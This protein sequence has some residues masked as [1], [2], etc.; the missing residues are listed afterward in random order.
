MRLKAALL[1][2][3]VLTGAAPLPAAAESCRRAVVFTLPGITWADVDEHRPP[4][5]LEAATKGAAGSV[6]VRT[7]SSRTSYASGFATLGAGARVEAGDTALGAPSPPDEAGTSE[8]GGS[9]RSWVR[10]AGVRQMRELAAEAGYGARPGALSSALAAS[11]AA[12]GNSDLG[13]DPPSPFGFGRWSLLAAMDTNGVVDLAATS[14]D[15]LRLDPEAPFGVTL[16][17]D[18]VEPLLEDALAR[19]CVVLFVDPGDLIRADMHSAIIGASVDAARSAALHDAD[20][21]LG[22]VMTK[23]DP[24]RDLLLVVTPTSPAWADE[25]HLGVAVATGPGFAAGSTLESASTRRRGIVTLPDVAPTVVDAFGARLPPHMNGR[26]WRSVPSDDDPISAALALDRESVFLDAVDNRISTGYVVVQVLVYAAA[27]AALARARRNAGGAARRVRRAALAVMAFP[28]ATYL[29][30]A[31]P[32]HA[33]GA[34]GYVALLLAITVAVVGLAEAA[35]RRPLDRVLLITALTVTVIAVDVITGARLQLN[36]VFGYSPI[37]AGRFAGIGNV[38]YAVLGITAI[39]TVALVAERTNGNRASLVGG[40]AL[41]LTVVIV[42][43]APQFGSDV[44]G[45]LSLVPAFGLTLLLLSGRRPRL[46]TIMAMILITGAL[47]GLFL[48]LDLSR[49]VGEQTHLARLWGDVT[50]RGWSS[51]AQVVERK[52]KANIRVFTSTIWTYFVPPAL[53]ALALL[54]LKPIGRWNE[55]ADRHPR[56]RS[57]LIG[58]LA[59]GIFGFAVNDSGIVIPAVALSFLVP[60]AI[61]LHTAEFHRPEQDAA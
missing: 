31:A 56:I 54:L 33:L 27:V 30:G 61:V 48:A 50:A 59:L 41:F 3:L 9:F 43:G 22:Y 38:A 16:D 1:L 11:V 44:G 28:V 7:I 4:H 45:V 19:P 17:E 10:V 37:V 24:E 34:A 55:L 14:T 42:D 53:A 20:R 12:I 25:A 51:F 23:L 46:R 36:T 13:I 58:G 2:A 26:A 21:L 5:L 57:G 35:L 29:A 40:T 47:L 32:A 18:R 8:A 15:L 6:S 52:A 60:L 39:L 49:P